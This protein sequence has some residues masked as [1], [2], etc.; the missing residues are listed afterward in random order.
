MR[1][2]TVRRGRASETAPGV[3]GTVRLDRRTKNLTKRLRPG[4]I[5]LIDH[6]DIDR[7]SADSLVACKVGAVVNAASSISGRYPNLGPG[8]L[9]D[10]GPAASV[11][12]WLRR[13]RRWCPAGTRGRRPRAGARRR[14]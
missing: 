7:V 3:T 11:S 14:R 12:W 10:P 6:V 1:I 13:A 4:D 2:G 9:V 8:I 5:A